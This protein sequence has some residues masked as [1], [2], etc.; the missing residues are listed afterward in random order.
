MGEAS[1]GYMDV[2]SGD[3]EGSQGREQTVGQLSVEG[4]K[5]V[6]AAGNPVQLRVHVII[7][8]ILHSPFDQSL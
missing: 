5:L 8:S 3:E 2:P 7:C 6:D 1:K 4:T